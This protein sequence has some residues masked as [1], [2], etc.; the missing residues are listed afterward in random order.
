[1]WNRT[2]TARAARVEYALG[3]F[4][5]RR[6]CRDA[7]KGAS[8][9]AISL[10]ESAVSLSQQDAVHLARLISDVEIIKDQMKKVAAILNGL[11][12]GM[13][14]DRSNP[15]PQLSEIALMLQTMKVHVDSFPIAL[16]EARRWNI[17]TQKAVENLAARVSEIEAKLGTNCTAPNLSQVKS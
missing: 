12:E 13:T 5:G 9:V 17:A 6:R 14:R 10:E 8:T 1:M 7:M 2:D 15:Q 4:A 11:A 16:R 3:S